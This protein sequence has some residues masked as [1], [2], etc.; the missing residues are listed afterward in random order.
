[1]REINIAKNIT[2][3][4]KEKN[5][6]QEQLA[7]ELKISPQ[8]VSKW[9]TG[10]SQPDALTLPLIADYFNVS[11]DYLYYGNDM[12]YDDIYRQISKKVLSHPFMSKETFKEACKISTYACASIH[13][14]FTDKWEKLTEANFP[15]HISN[16]NGVAVMFE[17]GYA[18]I[19]LRKY[20]ESMDKEFAKYA[21]DLLNI[22]SSKNC[23]FIL[24]SVVSMSDISFDEMKEKLS[25]LGLN[26]EEISEAIQKLT[27]ANILIEKP[28]KHKSLLRTYDIN[29]MYHSFICILLASLK[30][31]MESLRR[32]ISCCASFGDFPVNF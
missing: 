2:D 20:F 9:E 7:T 27:E 4:R 29:D 23:I 17:N 14:S 21:K 22:L 13:G 19:V 26:E 18:A 1:M 12:A 31:Q 25:P 5:I 11:I 3:L 28:S 6:T 32:G 15:L 10:T 16:E 8:A 30:M 24:M